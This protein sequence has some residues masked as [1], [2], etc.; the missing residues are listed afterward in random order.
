MILEHQAL[1]LDSYHDGSASTISLGQR[2]ASFIDYLA[3]LTLIWARALEYQALS[4]PDLMS[5]PFYFD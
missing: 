3:M 4:A 5:S 2:S 1:D